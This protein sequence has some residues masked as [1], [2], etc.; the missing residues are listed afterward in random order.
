MADTKV[1]ALTELTV[2]PADADEIYINDGGTSKKITAANLLNPE[3]L[4]EL[5]AGAATT[6][7]VAIND[8]GVG[9][10][11][12]VSNLLL[13]LTNLTALAV[14]PATGDE[15]LIND[16][17]TIKKITADD[18]M[19][20]DATTPTTQAHGD[21]AATGSAI[22]AARIDHKHAMPAAGGGAITR[23][24]GD[25]TE[26]TTTTTTASDLLAAASLT[27]AAAEHFLY[28]YDGRKTSGAASDVS[29][30]LKLNTTTVF[31]AASNSAGWNTSTTDR[32]ESGAANVFVGARVTNYVDGLMFGP[33]LSHSTAQVHAYSQT[34]PAQDASAAFP[35]AEITDLTIRGLVGNASLTLGTDELHVYSMA[36]S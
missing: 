5:A 33:S 9:K 14:S 13:S 34:F 35:T 25:T 11:I 18:F 4:T 22:E 8:G 6:D 28:Q 29:C 24:G 1:S 36:A 32:A 21:A 23:E 16:G 31:E 30:G 10:K 27:I 7:E 26:A 17:G 2:G 19:F 15:L 3:N 20:G 12:S